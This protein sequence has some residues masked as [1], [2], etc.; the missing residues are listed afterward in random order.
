VIGDAARYLTPSPSNIAA[1]SRIR[2]S[3]LRLLTALHENKD[4]DRIVFACHSLGAVIGYDI[5]NF[6]WSTTN[7]NVHHTLDDEAL[8]DIEQCIHALRQSSGDPVFL[9]RFRDAQRRYARAVREVSNDKWKVTDFVTLGAPLTYAYLLM[10]DDR[11]KLLESDK[12]AIKTGWLAEWR[13]HLDAKTAKVAE[14]FF[15]R[16]A[17]REFPIC[18]PLPEEG[19]SFAYNVPGVAYLIPHHAAVFAPVRWTNIFSPCHHVFWG[20]V[21]GGP[22]VPIFGPGVKDVELTG[23]VGKMMLAHTHYWDQGRKDDEHLAALRHALN[24]LDEE[25]YS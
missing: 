5:L 6:Y 16:T 1:R 23:N 12:E 10:V 7:A 22:V 13:E 8:K 25:E 9:A 20:D 4:Y 3:G 14:L 21:I 24:F 2:T 19:D 11:D 18:P 17:Q 15:A